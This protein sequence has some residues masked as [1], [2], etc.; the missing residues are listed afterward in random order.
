MVDKNGAFSYSSVRMVNNYS[1]YEASIYPNPAKDNLQVLI[2]TET[3]TNMQLQILSQEG[4]IMLSN[5][6][7]LHVGSL[8]KSININSL[9]K[10]IYFL[11]LKVSEKEEHVIKF[12]KM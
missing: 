4:K 5:N 2:T 10:G 7:A 11:K 6:F 9:S 3:N 1:S 12:E 8:L